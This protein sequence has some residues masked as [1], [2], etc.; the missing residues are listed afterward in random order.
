MRYDGIP[1][2]S[3]VASGISEI[4]NES[5]VVRMGLFI[6]EKLLKYEL[7]HLGKRITETHN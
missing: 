2:S 7:G 3:E 1:E 4:S 6:K 5:H